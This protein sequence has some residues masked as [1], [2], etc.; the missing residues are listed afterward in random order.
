MVQEMERKYF[1]RMTETQ[2][3]NRIKQ[4]VRECNKSAY[5]AVDLEEEIK[6][7]KETIKEIIKL[8]KNKGDIF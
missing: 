1:D 8:S 7:N 4:L 6:K 2:K 5:K 3:F